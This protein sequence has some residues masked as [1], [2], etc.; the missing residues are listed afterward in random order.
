MSGSAHAQGDTKPVFLK[1]GD[2]SVVQRY[3]RTRIL[4]VAGCASVSRRLGVGADTVRQAFAETLN[5]AASLQGL[6]E[7]DAAAD[8]PQLQLSFGHDCQYA[9]TLLPTRLLVLKARQRSAPRLWLRAFLNCS[10]ALC[11]STTSSG[12][13]DLPVS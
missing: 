9:A 7:A 11:M 5:E 2:V 1:G 6:E 4:A 12:G 8:G 10:R 3:V 13:C